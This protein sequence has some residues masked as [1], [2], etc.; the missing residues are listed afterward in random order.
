MEIIYWVN[1]LFF[2]CNNEDIYGLEYINIL[3]ELRYFFL[4]EVSLS[5]EG[6]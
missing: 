3:Y 2:I 5:I 4:G 6:I 1:I